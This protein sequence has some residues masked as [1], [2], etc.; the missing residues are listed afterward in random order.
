[1]QKIPL[2]LRDFEI[3][4]L[5]ELNSQNRKRPRNCFRIRSRF[6]M[7]SITCTRAFP[8]AP[9]KQ[10]IDRK[11]LSEY[12]MGLSDPIGN[13]RVTNPK[14]VQT[15]FAKNKYTVHYITL[16]PHVNLGLNVT[17]VHQF[18]QLNKSGSTRISA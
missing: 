13:R 6:P 16:K 14:H 12:Q 4:E 8:M 15:L 5:V 3:V 18:L 2:P 17:K 1:M 7:P 10:K 11:M 9:T